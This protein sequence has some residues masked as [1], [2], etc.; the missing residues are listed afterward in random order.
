MATQS[1]DCPPLDK[2]SWALLP[3]SQPRLGRGSVA[4][5][6]GVSMRLWTLSR[7][8]VTTSRTCLTPTPEA[9]PAGPLDGEDLALGDGLDRRGGKVKGPNRAVKP[10]EPRR[11]GLLT[12][13]D[14]GNERA[15]GLVEAN[16]GCTW[17]GDGG[18]RTL[19]VALAQFGP[20]FVRVDLVDPHA[21]RVY[22]VFRASRPACHNSRCK[23]RKSCRRRGVK[24]LHVDV[25]VSVVIEKRLPLNQRVPEIRG[26]EPGNISTSALWA[27]IPIENVGEVVPKQA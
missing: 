15:Q 20:L 21:R 9:A 7:Q 22:A 5:G 17:A 14:P 11:A 19:R 2:V 13:L 26:L 25:S 23:S 12:P 6:S 10:F 1:T 27:I 24:R 4:S 8:G 18:L 16:Q 3:T